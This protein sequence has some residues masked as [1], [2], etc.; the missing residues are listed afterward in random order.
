[1]KAATETDERGDYELAHVTT[2]TIEVVA[3]HEGYVQAKVKLAPE[4]LRDGGRLLG[5]DLVLEAGASIAGRV[6]FPDGTPAAG[7]AVTASPDTSQ[8][9]TS[10]R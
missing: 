7:A 2:G 3:S 6:S 4:Q 10:T 9:T 5:I 8:L 1:M